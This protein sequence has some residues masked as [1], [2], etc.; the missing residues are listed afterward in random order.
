MALLPAAAYPPPGA[1]PVAVRRL[2][3]ALWWSACTGTH[4]ERTAGAWASGRDRGMELSPNPVV[5]LTRSC[6]RLSP[7]V[8][9]S[10]WLPCHCWGEQWACPCTPHGCRPSRPGGHRYYEVDH[11]SREG[12]R[13]VK[14]GLEGPSA[15]APGRVTRGEELVSHG[16][17]Y[18]LDTLARVDDSI[19]SGRSFSSM[20]PA[21]DCVLSFPAGNGSLPSARQ[22]VFTRAGVP[23]APAASTSGQTA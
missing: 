19:R 15:H 14:V 12:R 7:V 17:P 22:R 18:A 9:A 21:R 6:H 2:A 23:S 1:R 13:V 10:V 3:V 8:T 11:G 5:P 4:G 20:G 16:T